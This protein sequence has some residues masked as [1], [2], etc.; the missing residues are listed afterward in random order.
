MSPTAVIT[1]AYGYVGSVLRS[2]LDR[3]GWRTVALVR[4]PRPGDRA[5]A[6]RLGEDVDDEVWEGADAVVHA[7]Y[8]MTV[9]TRDDIWRVNVEG[10]SRVLGSAAR[11]GI[12]RLLVIS[13]MSAYPGTSQLYGSAKL[14]IEQRAVELGGIALRPGL[15]YGSRPRG[16]AGT[17]L[18]LT[19]LPVV[20]VLTGG[21]SQFPVHEDDLAWVVTSLLSDPDWTAE[22]FGVAQQEPVS[23][24]D[25][26][27]V[28]AAQESRTCRFLPVPWRLAYGALRAAETLGVP[29][30]VR[31]DSV[32]GLVHPALSVPVS[33][34]RPDL[35][36][37]LRPLGAPSRDRGDA[38]G[39]RQPGGMARGTVAG[40]RRHRGVHGEEGTAEQAARDVDA[41]E[42]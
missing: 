18:R 29:L 9:R 42:R 6:W 2:A 8:D 3:A 36:A 32:A 38:G 10:S 7:A 27:S 24:R 16:M 41:G 11:A 21:G 15:V 35:A 13:S 14:E 17:L 4:T 22:V 26:L 30:P 37:T 40:D 5:H 19:R 1:G 12:R 31:S 20:P 28:L 33:R 23:L 25:L 34:A 39:G